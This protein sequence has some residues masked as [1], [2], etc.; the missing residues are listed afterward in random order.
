MQN[1]NIR[2][3]SRKEVNIAIEWA[4]L[5]GWNPGLHDADCFY[6]SDPNGFFIGELN[7]EPIGCISAV[8]YGDDFG[9]VGF[10]IVRPE[11]RYGRYAFY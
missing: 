9:F 1:F 4:A 8:S 7:G 10:F 5:E 3:M 11:F 6:A 2:T